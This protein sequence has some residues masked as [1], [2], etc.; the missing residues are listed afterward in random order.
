MDCGVGGITST[1]DYIIG[2]KGVDTEEAYPYKVTEGK[3]K[4]NAS[5]VGATMKG[6]VGINSG[7]ENALLDAVVSGPVSVAFESIYLLQD[8]EKGIFYDPSCKKPANLTHAMTIV[9]YCIVRN[10]WRQSRREQGYGRILRGKNLC[11]IA[12]FASY[13]VV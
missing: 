11:R 13:P 3:C 1:F 9:A 10:S 6:H 12:D 4:F 5:A 7:Y 8:Y 2:N